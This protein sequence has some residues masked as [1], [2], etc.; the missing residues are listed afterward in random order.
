ML[1]TTRLLLRPYALSDLDDA[2]AVLESHPDVWRYDP[3]RQR[4]REER[5]E[6]LQ[7]RMLELKRKGVGC[8][9]VVRH[10]D[11]RLIGYC[12]LQLYL[13]QRQPLS[14]TEVELFYRLG[15]DYWGQGYATEAA[16]AVVAH[17]FDTLRLPRLVSWADARN[18]RSIAL[19]RRLG[20][21]VQPAEDEPNEVYGVLE[22]PVLGA[23]Q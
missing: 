22:N 23:S 18:E 8:F 4:T 3:G 14:S 13:W 16:Q 1:T 7:F 15:R 9:A 11:S 20:F 2:Y 12:G 21:T 5:A 17:A 10:E 19:L 6:E